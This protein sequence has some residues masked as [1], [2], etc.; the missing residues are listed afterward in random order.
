M[1]TAVARYVKPDRICLTTTSTP[2]SKLAPLS[3]VTLNPPDC[4]AAIE[5]DISRATVKTTKT[6]S[7]FTTFLLLAKPIS[8]CITGLE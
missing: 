7:R 8:H 6:E 1:P 3:H 5:A 2:L 4:A